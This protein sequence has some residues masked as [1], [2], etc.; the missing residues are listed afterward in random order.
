MKWLS[1]AHLGKHALGEDNETAWCQLGGRWSG[2]IRLADMSFRKHRHLRSV[3]SVREM[4]TTSRSIAA[5][6]QKDI[7]ARCC[8]R[9]IVPKPVCVRHAHRGQQ[10]DRR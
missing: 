7:L 4:V 2:V 8:R 6:A 5:D 9:D 3:S 1:E 10:T